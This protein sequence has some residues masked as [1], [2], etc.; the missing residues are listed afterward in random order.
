MQRFEEQQEDEA[1]DDPAPERPDAEWPAA[2]EER[3]RGVIT[4]SAGN[5][6]KGVAIAAGIVG[7]RATVV[8]PLNAPLAK[9]EATR[10]YG[11]RVVLHG[12]SYDDAHEQAHRL[13]TARGLKSSTPRRV[14]W[15]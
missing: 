10:G 4:A 13:A 11:A 3:E 2:P 15:G 1:Q 14:T 6:G 7:C 9:V 5:H 8:M 12:G